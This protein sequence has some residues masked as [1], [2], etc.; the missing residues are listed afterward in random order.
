MDAAEK[1]GG[2]RYQGHVSTKKH[3]VPSKH[4]VAIGG[5]DIS[6]LYKNDC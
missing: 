6:F 4:T 2:H 1:L 5:I 3:L